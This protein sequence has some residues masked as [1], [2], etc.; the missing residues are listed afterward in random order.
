MPNMDVGV[1]PFEVLAVVDHGDV[2]P[3]FGYPLQTHERRIADEV[4][5]SPF[6]LRCSSF[7]YAL[8]PCSTSMNA[9]E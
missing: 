4:L 8:T 2:P 1:D 3:V 6:H 5:E 9:A 7:T